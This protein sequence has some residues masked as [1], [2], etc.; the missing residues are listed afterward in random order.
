MEELRQR[1]ARDLDRSFPDLVRALQHEVFSGLRG[2]A[3]NDAEDLA[4]ETFI[5]AYRALS[6]Y[7]PARIEELAVRPW[8]WTIALNLG[9]NHL[10]D[11][12]RRPRKADQ[13][14]EGVSPEPLDWIEWE[15]RLAKLSPAQR[16]AVV[17]RHVVG[18]N[19][20]EI[21]A[22]TGR[23]EGSVKA[24]VHRGINRL[25]QLMEDER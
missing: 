15:E 2:M 3:G 9:R 18:L 5:R 24:D 6:D 17:L 8:I 13:E 1:L 22:A 7:P 16:R 10:R 4:Q 12:S 14:P 21:A 11:Q 23:A 25:R 20:E 19:Y